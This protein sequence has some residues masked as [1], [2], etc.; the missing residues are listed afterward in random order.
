MAKNRHRLKPETKYQ[1]ENSA[2]LK[3][4]LRTIPV[5]M[6]TVKERMH[7]ELNDKILIESKTLLQTG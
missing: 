7:I 5:L 4:L 3:D 2:F 1:I 6:K